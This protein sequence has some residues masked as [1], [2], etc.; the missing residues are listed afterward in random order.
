MG[1]KQTLTDQFVADVANGEFDPSNDTFKLALYENTADLD[2]TTAVYTTS[3]E[4]SGTGY[5]A[6]GQELTVAAG[7]PIMDGRKRLIDFDNETFSNVS[8]TA[9]GGLIY[10]AS[11][12]NKSVAVLNFGTDASPSGQ[13]LTIEFPAADAAHAILRISR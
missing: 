3:G 9:R 8:L 2:E 10:N 5:T 1:I 7:V 4:S 13:D 12:S 11:R 6:G